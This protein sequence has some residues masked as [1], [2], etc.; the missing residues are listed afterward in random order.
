MIERCISIEPWNRPDAFELLDW[1]LT[2]TNDEES[3]IV[4]ENEQE[5]E[6]EEGEGEEYKSSSDEINASSITMVRLTCPHCS[7]LIEVDKRYVIFEKH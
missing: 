2:N 4:D 7:E 6:E 3:S 5:E 1:D